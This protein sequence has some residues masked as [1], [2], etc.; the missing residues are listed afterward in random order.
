MDEFHY[1]E[2]VD[3][4]HI[5]INLF[6]DAVLTHPAVI[7]SKE[8]VTLGEEIT[9]KMYEFYRLASERADERSSN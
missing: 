6:Y 3:R 7:D 8:L 2:V 5:A 1:H 4:T 9:D